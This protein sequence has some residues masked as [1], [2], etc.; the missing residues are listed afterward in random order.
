MPFCLFCHKEFIKLFCRFD[1]DRFSKEKRETSSE[2]W[3]C[4]FGVGKR[5]CL[6]RLFPYAAAMVAIVTLLRKFQ[7]SMSDENQKLSS[8]Y[9][10]VTH[11]KEEI[12][13]KLS[14]R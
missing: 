7:I 10:I 11:H 8:P 13:V 4:P 9:G 12:F 5:V 1:P 3:F 6:V 2:F 14:A